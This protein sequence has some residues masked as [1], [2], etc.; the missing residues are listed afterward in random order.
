LASVGGNSE[1]HA[2]DEYQTIGVLYAQ[3]TVEVMASG[4]ILDELL[5]EGVLESW[6]YA[7]SGAEITITTN[8]I[9]G[10]AAGIATVCPYPA[11]PCVVWNAGSLV[12]TLVIAL[13]PAVAKAIRDATKDRHW[14]PCNPPVGTLGFLWHTV[15]DN[16]DHFPFGENHVHL[17]QPE[18]DQRVVFL[19]KPQDDGR[20]TSAARR[21][22]DFSVRQPKPHARIYLRI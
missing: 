6:A 13:A 9:E 14:K 11:P 22:S 21:G 16:H 17:C 8:S 10:L 7:P 3:A 2:I 5:Q 20:A 15:A 19:G 18:S 1:E 12:I 4:E